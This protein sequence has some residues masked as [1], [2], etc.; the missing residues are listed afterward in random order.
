MAEANLKII[1]ELQMVLEEVSRNAEVKSL[2]INSSES[3]TRD[4]KL[5]I[6]RLVGILLK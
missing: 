6:Q 2:F 3:F 5:T 1:T 4:R